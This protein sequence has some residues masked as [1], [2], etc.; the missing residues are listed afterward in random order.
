[1]TSTSS[2][3]GSRWKHGSRLLGTWPSSFS[4][5]LA[6]AALVLYAVVMLWPYLAATLV[7]GSAVT[8]WTHLATAPIQG[9]APA[10]L[11]LIGATVGAD[12]V[13]LQ[14]VNDRLDP[15]P[16]RLAEAALANAR[17]RLAAAT[18]YLDSVQELDRQ[19]RELMKR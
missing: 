18:D 2:P 5:W 11:P 4:I 17:T 8:A 16:V 9:R 19:R 1:M 14:I 12:G 6:A 7:R 15:A 13:I 3:R 10:N